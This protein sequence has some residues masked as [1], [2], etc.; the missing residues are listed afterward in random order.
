MR[1][2]AAAEAAAQEKRRL[3]IE[4]LRRQ[5][6]WKTHEDVEREH[7]EL[8]EAEHRRRQGVFGK[9]KDVVRRMP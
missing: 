4:E 2:V 5:G 8:E 7:R 6:K 1:E 9:L 3:E